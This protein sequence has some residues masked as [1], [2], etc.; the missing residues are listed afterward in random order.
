MGKKRIAVIPGDGIG[1]ETVPE[2]LRVLD[3][4]A[5][6]FGLDLHYDHF[7]FASCDYFEKHG[8]MM[9]ADWKDRIGA[10]DAIFYGAVGWPATVPDHVSLWGSLIK[11]RR[12][13]DQYINLRPCKLMPGIRSPLVRADGSAR[14][15]GEIDF[16]VVAP[17]ARIVLVEQ[18]SGFLTETPDGLVKKYSGKDKVVAVQLGRTLDALRARLA[19]VVQGEAVAIDYLLYCPDYTVKQSG[20]AGLPP[21]RIVDERS[22]ERLCARIREALPEEAPRDVLAHKLRR[23]FEVDRHY[24]TVAALKALA[25]DGAVPAAK[26]AAAMKKYGIDPA[27]PAPWTV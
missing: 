14:S 26:V 21:E 5:R 8:A 23:F 2:G 15:A 19:P 25:D 27:K 20:T 3:A 4:A 12:E 6:R 9:P 1:K 16:V 18:K 10:H 22:R 13:F 11:F 7:D 24:V 17:S